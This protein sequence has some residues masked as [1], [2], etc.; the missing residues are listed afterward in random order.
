MRGGEGGGGG[1]G[2]GGL[3]Q[4]EGD[5]R[6]AGE[7]QPM[8]RY[9]TLGV[10]NVLMMWACQL[11]CTDP[12]YHSICQHRGPVAVVWW[13]WWWWRVREQRNGWRRAQ[14]TAAALRSS[15]RRFG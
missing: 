6:T 8:E 1:G 9:G 2:G 11:R 15:R 10:T 12:S 3:R 5:E 14:R 4:T 7:Q 13:R